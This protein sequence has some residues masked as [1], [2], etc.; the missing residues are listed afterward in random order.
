[1]SESTLKTATKSGGKTAAAG[2]MMAIFVF[3]GTGGAFV[4]TG[5][6]LPDGIWRDVITIV[7]GFVFAG[8]FLYLLIDRLKSLFAGNGQFWREVLLAM[9]NVT[10]LLAAFAAIYR[11][12]GIMDSRGAGDPTETR[13][14]ADCAYYS[15]VTFTTLGYGDFH[16]T[17]PARII[18]GLQAFLGY[19]VL[20]VLASSSAELIKN[21][22]KED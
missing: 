13:S 16:P 7:G 20:G 15:V 5:T 3:L 18:A 10:V 12:I 2:G 22:A 19:L 14:Y 6:F 11:S 21:S 8:A 1:M 17:G 9:L 4:G